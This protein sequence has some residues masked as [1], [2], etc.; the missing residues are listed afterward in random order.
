MASVIKMF[1]GLC[2]RAVLAVA[3]VV[4]FVA[5]AQAPVN[6]FGP[7]SISISPTG[8]AGANTSQANSFARASN[9]REPYTL[10]VENLSAAFPKGKVSSVAIWLNSVKVAST[11]D[12]F[13][14][15]GKPVAKFQKA[16]TV[17]GQN[18]LVV[19]VAG[20]AAVRLSYRVVATPIPPPQVVKL[21]PGGLSIKHGSSGV[22]QATLSPAPTA[23]GTMT[24]VTS[25]SEIADVPATIPF[26]AGQTSVAVPVYGQ[27]LGQTTLSV[28]LN[29]S[30]ESAHVNVTPAGARLLTLT[31]L[32]AAINQGSTAQFVVS[33]RP[34]RSEV[35]HQVSLTSSDTAKVTVPATLTI[36]AGSGTA[37]FVA[38]GVGAGNA[39]ITARLVHRGV[40]SSASAQV[41]VAPAPPTVTS[42]LPAN[43]ALIKGA[44]AELTLSISAAQSTSTTV[45][46]TARTGGV[47]EVAD[48]VTVP[49]GMTQV[50]IPVR[51]LE[52]GNTLIAAS[53]NGST[54]EAAVK[55]TPIPA[56]LASLEPRTTTFVV[57]ASG[58][59]LVKLNAA[60]PTPTTVNLATEPA[61]TIQV[62]AQVTIPA[63]QLEAPILVTA[64]TV[65]QADVVASLNGSLRRASVTV[66][67]EPSRVEQLLPDPLGLQIGASAN[68][69]VRLNAAPQEAVTVALSASAPLVLRVP[70]SVTIAAGQIEQTFSVQGLA[71]G[72]SSVTASLNGISRSSTVNVVAPPPRIAG[73]E[74]AS[75]DL[76]KGKL[77][78]L[79]ITLDKAPESAA[80]VNLSNS[81]SGVL[82]APAQVTVAAGQ[83][84][85]EVPLV[86]LQ[87]G[88]SS[89]T[90]TL[91]DSTAASTVTVVAAEIVAISVTP[92]PASVSPGQ[93]V[94]LQA[95][96]T[97]SDGTTKD[98][99]NGAGTAWS[100]GS[101]AIATVTAEGRLTG[102]EQ[103]ETTVSAMQ[104]VLPTWGNPSPESVVG[105]ATVT[106][107]PPSPMALST[108]KTDLVVGESTAV[109][110]T[111]PY[112]AVNPITVNL[113]TSGTGA[114]QMPAQAT[115]G[116]GLTSVS[117]TVQ[118]ASAG[119]VVLTATASPFAPG[120]LTF[121]VSNPAP[122]N[123]VVTGISPTSAAPGANVTITGSGF[124]SPAS[125]N[126]VTFYGNVP[127]VVQSGSAT[128]LVVKVADAAQTGPITVSNNLGS[129]Q[130]EVFTVIREQDFGLQAS[131]AYLKVMQ[132]SN[133]IA[134]L[135]LA[136]SGTRPYQGLAKLSATG[137]PSGVQAKFEPATLSA[138]QTGKLI[139]QAEGSAPLGTAVLTIRAE[140]TL[141]GLPWVRESRIN[142]E[143]ITKENV[144][145]VK[146][147]FVTPAGS[148]IAGVIVRMDATTNQVVTDAAG[149]FLLTGLASGVTTL[150]FDA[151]PANALYPIWPYN[152]TLEAGQLLT[153]S[154][155]V[156]NPPPADDKFK[157][158]NNATQDQA[159]TDERYPGFAV[160]LPAG[161]TIRGWDGVLKTRIAV[162]RIEPDKLPVALPP[163]A[164]K[165]AYQLYFGTPM[166]GLPSQ[167]IPVTL[168][169]VADKEPG[170]KVEIWFFDGSPMGGTGEWKMAGLGTVSDDGKT[171]TSDPGAGLT[172]FCGVCGLVSLNCPPTPKPP[173]P[174]PCADCKC[175]QQ[176]TAGNPVTLFTG[177]EHASHDGMSIAGLTPLSTGLKY[178][179]VDAFNNRAGTVASFGYGWTFGYDVSFLPF[180]GPQK[181]L[182]LPGGQ[183]VNLVDD[184]TGKY[185]PVD[186]PRQSGMY[187]RDAGSGQW[188]MV[189]KGGTTWRFEPFAGITGVIR[190]GPPLFLTR[191]TDS[192]GNVTSISRHSNGRIQAIAGAQGRGMSFAYTG[193]FVS[194][195]EDH[196]GRRMSFEYTP[197]IEEQSTRLR[198]K[199]ITDALGRVTIY[200]YDREG[201][202]VP[203]V[204]SG[205]GGGGGGGA[206]TPP[207]PPPPCST[208]PAAP[209]GLKITQIQYPY[210]EQ[211]TQN[212]YSAS[213][214]VI[215]QTASDG[216][217][218]K[219]G[220]R[221]A[222]ACVQRPT[223]SPS[224]YEH[225]LDSN[226][227]GHVKALAGQCPAEDNEESQAAGWSF[228]G[229]SVLQARVTQPDGG[230]TITRFNPRGM[231]TEVIDALGQSTKNFYDAKQQR[232]KTI[233]AL[234]REVKYEY[235]QVGNR[236]AVIDPL[237]RR[238]ETGY[239]PVLNQPTSTTQFLLG[240]P[241]T[242]GGQQLSYTPVIQSMAYDSRGNAI[243]GTDPTGMAG[244]MAYDAKGL[245]SQ[246]TLTAQTAAASVPIVSNGAASSILKA[247]RKITLG[248]NNAGD[249]A[250]VTDGQNNE[251][252]FT[253]DA[254][255]RPST[256]TDA[257]GY[258]SKTEYN[259][260]DQATKATNA[261]NQDSRLEYDS[262]AR[263]TGVVNEAN[264]TIEGYGYD[265]NGRVSRITDALGQNTGVDYDAS[266][267]PIR[268]TDR[269]GQVTTIT[270]N[271][272]GQVSQVS[273]PGQTIR[274]Q[275]DAIGR[276][277]EVRDATS[278][279]GYQYDAAD[280]IVQVDSATAAGSHRL[281]YEHDSLDR[282]TKRIL[283]GTGIQAPE[284]TTYSWDLAGRI[285][286]H[287]TTVGGQSHSTRYEYDVAGRLAARKVQADSQIDFVTQR[288]GYDA[289]ERLAQ[290]KYVK[291]EG[292][293]QEQLIEQIDYGYDAK[294]QRTSKT[295]LNN[296]GMGA[297]ETPMTA[298]YDTANRMTG[299]TLSIAGTTKTYSLTYD[300]NGNLIE[301]ANTAE[302]A[303][304]TSY[305]WDTNNRLT[306]ITQPGLTAAFGYDASGRRIQSVITK[307]GQAPATVQYLYEGAQALGEIRDGKLSHRLLTGLSLD[308]TI[309]RVALNQAGQRDSGASRLYM[310]DA[311]NSVIAQL[312]DDSNASIT[313]SYGYSP[314]GEAVTVGPDSTANP[315]QYTSRENDRTGLMFYRARYY[316]P[317]L[318]RFIS[319][320]PIGLAGGLN[321]RG[322]VE[323]DPLSRVDPTGEYWIYVW[324]IVRYVGRHAI[325]GLVREWVKDELRP[326][327]PTPCV[328]SFCSGGGGDF[329]GGGAGGS[330]DDCENDCEERKTIALENCVNN[331]ENLYVCMNKIK[332]L[333]QTP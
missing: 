227:A 132:G 168:P 18:Q 75:Q 17:R 126:T 71:A 24:V 106:V 257:L 224:I 280:R 262:A 178:N 180:S 325:Y 141:D 93:S 312:G 235:D 76:P 127:A 101:S 246:I 166:G 118:A 66:T 171:V 149:N 159:V 183:F 205:G 59:L 65:G 134:V 115:I 103:G 263:L 320:D 221:Y 244:Q 44:T 136:T 198:I 279:N 182:V 307:A 254:L 147:R 48:A 226:V 21:G 49:P 32:Q 269:K 210:A 162:E 153:M 57:S 43:T 146:G 185:R 6:V 177:Q 50:A 13:N 206:S 300:N 229:G 192:N 232:I 23:A 173:Q 113:G 199:S 256:S 194:R 299:V 150:R 230:Q 94:Q 16:L 107:S 110:I 247:Q 142:V 77:G 97:Y 308:E 273:N 218:T 27:G 275:Y 45:A 3:A 287:T 319:S 272:R 278:V 157:A 252:R 237:G 193:D 181:R 38:T 274:Y 239:D 91:N 41:Q 135:N 167:P 316:D 81:N 213:G 160:V 174:C 170:E 130:S 9:M 215:R 243:A 143:V 212:V 22:L 204:V 249:L 54:V 326:P 155:W 209:R 116:A 80:V 14:P 161:V 154:D 140:A 305:T 131:P 84:T 266:A 7:Q 156:I 90:A 64:V 67:P 317:V 89:I 53:L 105:R 240:V 86:A 36:P 74:P 290:I 11:S 95:V 297:S 294:G 311:L 179:P 242:Q 281:Q 231:P 92:A 228:T 5:Q 225:C 283:S 124:A 306:N 211:P 158:I 277:L 122:V 60:Q 88:Q 87:L 69:T 190:G 303:D 121:N 28:Q 276:L 188:E 288:Y 42:L 137:L 318:K 138:Y 200:T 10:V 282:V 304:K 301:K 175:K 172:R 85:V 261:L 61:G 8:N 145:G 223:A 322:Y 331:G 186:D 293:A 191:I 255:G 63:G 119:S 55:V 125:A 197:T 265:T 68:I 82:S 220:Y 114:L 323:G 163:F 202:Y 117:V 12:L 245:L 321:M 201:V 270:Y 151:T 222:G 324:K 37:S 330:W 2:L 79:I 233:D 152:V 314:Y 264:V 128:Q 253:S 109:S 111:S 189:F 332:N 73:I 328:G 295:T 313:N 292:T 219:F 214:R 4:P 139:L 83:L 100:T 56:A 70:E 217:T 251:S 302:A 271:E 267:R 47:V 133:A 58:T 289:L 19:T 164:M 1:S 52:V 72:Q 285:L 34:A 26:A 260:L 296:N 104:P 96:A 187:A 309:A 148:G 284:A 169:N 298:T 329:G 250:V 234:G 268:I 35:M 176:G 241:S 259:A 216:T 310:T 144:T 40:N 258:S 129:A 78:K 165:E 112:P 33:V 15:S 196:T 29:G 120:Q 203:P 62:P 195:I 207:P 30:T 236:T 315:N 248:Y 184:G 39:Q 98:V 238:S 102:V 208:F 46:L 327:K 286:G 291:A 108:G 99:T 20:N 123:V 31:P 51:A 333:C 25:K